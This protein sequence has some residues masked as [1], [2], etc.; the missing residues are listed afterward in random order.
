MDAVAKYHADHSGR[1]PTGRL[2]NFAAMSEDKLRRVNR[3]V[4]DENND[5]EA[6]AKVEMVMRAKQMWQEGWTTC[7]PGIDPDVWDTLESLAL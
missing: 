6:I 3:A 4:I 7:P 1:G 5:L 2:R